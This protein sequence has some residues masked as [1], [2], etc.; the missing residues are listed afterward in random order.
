M[1][2]VLPSGDQVGSVVLTFGVSDDADFFRVF[3][4]ERRVVGGVVV[5]GRFG[6]VG[7]V[8][9]PLLG[10][11]ESRTLEGS[12]ANQGGGEDEDGKESH[13]RREMEK[14]RM[15]VKR[16]RRTSFLAFC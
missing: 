2:A 16:E 8:V 15:A 13:R 1:P 3:G 11:S 6:R 7:D 9:V 5:V 4:P 10:E 14:E 12:S